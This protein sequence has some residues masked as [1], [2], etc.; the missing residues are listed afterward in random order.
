MSKH[1]ITLAVAVMFLVAANAKA[2]VVPGYAGNSWI[3]GTHTWAQEYAV[4]GS[5]RLDEVGVFNWGLAGDTFM[6]GGSLKVDGQAYSGGVTLYGSSKGLVSGTGNN[7]TYTG[8]LLS[9]GYS[10]S[11]FPDF[12]GTYSFTY[13]GTEWDY[14]ALTGSN[15]GG[16]QAEFK[17]L[18][19]SNGLTG[20]ERQEFSI[21]NFS[22]GEHETQMFLFANQGWNQTIIDFVMVSSPIGN[23]DNWAAGVQFFTANVDP[24]TTPEPAT[25]AV[26]GLGLVGLGIARRRMKK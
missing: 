10:G 13:A 25:L 8:D 15:G 11:G 1:F 19:I 20:E 7:K 9:A 16:L 18:T 5:T 21:T 23:P 26:L 2:E 12:T 17:S 14:L 4:G 24:A 3:P 22:F 6:S